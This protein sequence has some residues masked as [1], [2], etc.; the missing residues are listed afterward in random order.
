MGDSQSCSRCQGPSTVGFLEDKGERGS[1]NASRVLSWISGAAKTG[2]LGG[3]KVL[4]K[5]RLP[6]TAYRCEACGHL[7]LFVH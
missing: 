1:I 2:P 5:E 6:V 3:A 4:G 7:D